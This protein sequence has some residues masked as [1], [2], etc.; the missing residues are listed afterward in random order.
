MN[1][2][3][4]R[5]RK[6]CHVPVERPRFDGR[7]LRMGDSSCGA[8][9]EAIKHRAEKGSGTAVVSADMIEE[10]KGRYRDKG[11]EM[12]GVGGVWRWWACGISC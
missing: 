3:G 4:M 10:W 9:E 2:V 5:V 7:G 11:Q 1:R 12:E 8:R 6:G